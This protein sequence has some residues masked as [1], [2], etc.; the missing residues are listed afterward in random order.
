[1][2]RQTKRTPDILDAA[3][4][5]AKLAN[6]S[7]STVIGRASGAGTGVPTAL[8]GSQLSTILG[9][10]LTGGGTVATGGFT[11]TV[12]ATGTAVLGTGASTRIPYW[13]G[14]NTLGSD[15]A[16]I[17]DAV[18]NWLGIGLTPTSALHVSGTITDT[19]ADAALGQFI[20]TVTP[21]VDSV[22]RY[23]AVFG[24]LRWSGAVNSTTR[25]LSAVRGVFIHNSTNTIALANGTSGQ[26]T[27]TAAGT[28]TTAAALQAVG[29]S[30][31]AGTT[32]G[33]L[34][35]LEVE[36]VTAG[37]TYNY[38]IR[39]GKG[40]NFLRDALKIEGWQDVV[41][42][43]V[44]AHAVNPTNHLVN[45][46]TSG[47]TVVGG[48][49]ATGAAFFGNTAPISGTQLYVLNYFTTD[50]STTVY[51]T[52]NQTS[53]GGSTAL[54]S[55]MYGQRN[56]A[57]AIGTGSINTI[58]GMLNQAVVSGGGNGTII[59]GTQSVANVNHASS[60]VTSAIG[61][62]ITV[63]KTLGTLSN[64]WGLRV[65][66][67]NTASVLNVAIETNA[68]NVIFNEGGDASTDFRVESDTE[69]NM[70]FVDANADTDGAVYLGGT[71]NGI[72]VNKGG[73]M[74]F[75]GT[76]TVWDDLR[77]EPIAKGTGSNNPTFGTWAGGISLY[78][79][80]NATAGSEKEVWFNVQMPHGWKEGSTVEPHV[81]WL[82]KTAGTAGQVIRWGLEYSK[83]KIGTAFST[84]PTTVYG[85]TIVGG[86]A[87][88]TA[89]AHLLTDFAGI[90]MTGDT[91][92]TVLVCRLF[93]NSS[94]AAD[95][96]TGTAGL[97]YIDW[98]VELDTF[99]SK[100]ELAK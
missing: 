4:T 38:A 2:T 9:G 33:T 45:Y 91:I 32:I 58:I 93:R 100:T 73:E 59:I 34:M 95:T 88:T 6:L 41:Q 46:T 75:I 31:F 29:A 47:D 76:A 49:T 19:A 72:K 27:T 12:P 79:F 5:L 7:E 43:K 66:D 57:R 42:L 21:V 68:G 30:L 92:S 64:A 67:V 50:P 17:W 94:D 52:Y 3:I 89:N 61:E 23:N 14:T 16:L 86:G 51:G 70:L 87:I 11:L 35:G 20:T 65:L 99:G 22:R 82:P 69:P 24:S 53:Y 15:N 85:T 1:M 56:L 10:T 13:T 25:L 37:S 55:Y 28:I 26:I 71:T 63:S 84:T 80:D 48:V 97:L 8:T 18:N 90:D 74:T 62:E 98:H 96:Y 39:T 83:A 78:E 81:H 60:T 40:I 44:R 54:S 77:I 36:D